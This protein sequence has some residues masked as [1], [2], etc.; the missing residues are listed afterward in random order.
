MNKAELIEAVTDRSGRS[1]AQTEDI[2]NAVLKTIS[3]TL[4]RGGNVRLLGLGTFSV[5]ERSAREGRNPANGEILKIP[6]KKAV[7]FKAG[8]A[9]AESVAK[10]S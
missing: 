9:L 1:K 2:V 5:V 7:R 8:K 4:E 3:E 6:A 10:T